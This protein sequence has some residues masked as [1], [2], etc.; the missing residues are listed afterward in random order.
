MTNSEAK[1]ESIISF[2][3]NIHHM[4]LNYIADKLG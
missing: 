3:N 1:T 4:L 2:K